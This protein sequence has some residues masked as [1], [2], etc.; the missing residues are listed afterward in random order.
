MTVNE[1]HIAVN[2]G[3]QKLASLQADVLL[4]E[5]IDFELNLAMLRFI[6]QRYN[7]ASNVK[8][9]GFEQS[10]KRIDDLR[11][12]VARHQ[13]TTF[14]EGYLT[15]NLGGYIYT[16]NNTNIY[17]DKYTLPLDYLYLVAVAA[18]VYYVCNTSIYSKLQILQNAYYQVEMDLTPPAPGY[19][20]TAVETFV[21]G[22]WTNVIN[23]PLGQ[24]IP[25]DVLINGKSY[26][27]VLGDVRPS[28]NGLDDSFLNVTSH[29][30]P[31][32]T[33]NRLYLTKPTPWTSDAT[34]NYLRLTWVKGGNMTT[35][36]IY[37][38]ITEV[39]YKVTQNRTAPTA[40]P[41]ISYC[42]FAQHDDYL[43]MMD[44]PFN[45]T[46]FREPIYTIDENFISVHTDSSF[47][48][49]R[50][51]ITYIR[52]PKQISIITGVG[53]ELPIQTHDEIIE[54]TV[55]SIL[56]GIES[57]RYQSQSM[58]TFESE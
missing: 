29:V 16:T 37:R 19:V 11:I 33:S 49:P 2:L 36:V 28:I 8:N 12:L 31:P 5:E 9:K 51:N 32:V 43:A 21:G 46:Y 20:L 57:Q 22:V 47:V 7:T 23:T 15:D 48:V 13:G 6:K 44:D 52:K 27:T 26:Q 3:V 10:Q 41:K 54:M 17:V 24:E 18:E 1:M 40:I 45:I 55:K 53:C 50:V 4:P 14:T 34:G 38:Y 58:E 39:V 42:S 56:E 30:D 35:G 25:Y